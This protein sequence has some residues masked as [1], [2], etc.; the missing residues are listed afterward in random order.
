MFRFDNIL[1]MWYDDMSLV[2][3]SLPFKF[4]VKVIYKGTKMETSP[5]FDQIPKN[6]FITTVFKQTQNIDHLRM[7][8]K[9]LD[10]MA[11]QLSL[12]EQPTQELVEAA[13]QCC[14]SAGACV[15][16]LIGF[17]TALVPQLNHMAEYA[18]K[19]NEIES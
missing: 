15:H 19:A 5:P 6:P 11:I 9:L 3:S 18:T 4:H 10:E 7:I 1:D 8:A 14:R 2:Y 12:G 17:N 13:A 16:A